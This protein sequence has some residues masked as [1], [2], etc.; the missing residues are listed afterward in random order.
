MTL[1][2]AEQEPLRFW[3]HECGVGVE[4]RV[5]ESSGEICCVQCGS[6]FVEEIEEDDPPQNFRIEHIEETPAQTSGASGEGADVQA[7]IHNEFGET[8]PLPRYEPVERYASQLRMNEM[9]TCRYLPRGTPSSFTSVSR[10][11]EERG[12]RL[13][14]WTLW[15]ACSR[16]SLATRVTMRLAIWLT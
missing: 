5:E 10:E 7:E 11:K 4:T 1:T 8:R 3:C 16:C 6:N 12:M 13:A 2:P 9:G 15:V 14:F